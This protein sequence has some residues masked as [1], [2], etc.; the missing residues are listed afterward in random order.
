MTPLYLFN[1]LLEAAFST[2][3]FC[4]ANLSTGIGLDAILHNR[5][6]FM[7]SNLNLKIELLFLG[8]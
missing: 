4:S 1:I 2:T 8:L 6:K 5:I 7:G 3:I